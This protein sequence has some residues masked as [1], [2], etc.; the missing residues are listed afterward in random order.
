M[1]DPLETPWKYPPEEEQEE[2]DIRGIQVKNTIP[3]VPDLGLTRGVFKKFLK[4]SGFG[5][6]NPKSQNPFMDF[7]KDPPLFQIWD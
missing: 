5:R 2:E 1:G 7:K 4:N 3:L 6:L